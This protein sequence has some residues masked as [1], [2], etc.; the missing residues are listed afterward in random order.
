MSESVAAKT[1]A[2]TTYNAAPDHER[3]REANLRYIREAGVGSVEA[4]VIYA[5]AVK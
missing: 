1:R 5:T 4:N 2:A 3:V